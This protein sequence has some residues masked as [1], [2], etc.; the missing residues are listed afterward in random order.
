MND[1]IK[2][3][4]YL[5]QQTLQEPAPVTP[6]GWETVAGQQS[7]STT[8]QG[9]AS[10]MTPWMY[11]SVASVNRAGWDLTVA[12]LAMAYNNPWTAVCLCVGCFVHF[13]ASKSNIDCAFIKFGFKTLQNVM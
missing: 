8:A 7:V 12:N 3:R 11:R 10:A 13:Q 4:V 1:F 5:T 9:E 6:T 2:K